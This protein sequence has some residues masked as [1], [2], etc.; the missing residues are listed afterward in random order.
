IGDSCDPCKN[1]SNNIDTD[2]DGISDCED[3]CIN[4]PNPAQNDRDND[5]VGDACD[6]CP[7]KKN[8]GQADADDDGIGDSCDPC[9]NLSNDIDTD[10]DGIS[11]C[12]DNCIDTTNPAQNDRDNDGVGDA[13]DNCPDK[14]NTGQADTDG[15]GIGNVCDP[16]NDLLNTLNNVSSLAK[17]EN[18]LIRKEMTAQLHPNPFKNEVNIEVAL[19][20]SGKISIQIF[21]LN[22]QLIRTLHQQEGMDGERLNVNWN[23]TNALGDL[24]SSGIYLVRIQSQSTV[25]NKKVLLQRD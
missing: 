3:N 14:K 9:K 7:D 25:I 2:G 23:G 13:C 11:D 6:N 12:E 10:G 19:V 15:D 24:L 22:G 1:L 20:E 21:N 4:T 17:A 8:P 5:G 16:T 18:R